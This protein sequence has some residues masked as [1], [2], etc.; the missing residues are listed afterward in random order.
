[1]VT[2]AGNPVLSSPNGTQLDE[3][4]ASLEF[5]VSIDIYINETTRHAHLILPPTTGLETDHYDLAF[6]ALAVRN[7]AKYSPALFN[8]SP[9]ARHDWKILQELRKRLEGDK[10]GRRDIFH[11]F[12]PAKIIDLALRYGPYG[13]WGKNRET[14]A[15]GLTLRKLERAVHGLDLGPLQPCLPSRLSTRS[16]RIQLAPDILVQ[17]LSRLRSAYAGQSEEAASLVL[18]GRRQLRS[19]NSWMHNSPRLVRGKNR[20][21]LL[22]HPEDAG[23]RGIFDGQQ[24]EVSSRAGQVKIVAEISEEMMRGVVS[25]P[26][27]WGH[28]RPGIEMAVARDHAGVSIND[29]TDEQFL[30]ELTG[31][32]SFSG[33]PVLVSGGV[34]RSEGRTMREL[35]E[36]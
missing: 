10:N 16:R 36:R 8:P 22:M 6:H 14:P 21:T 2:T 34:T 29:L 31:N 23:A 11:R 17:D 9:E 25:I 27:G 35:P 32:A 28:N 30:D 3:A 1:M 5:M 4:L 19:N 33:V 12:S 13:A 26:H 15:D 18:I 7:T 20:C 24:V